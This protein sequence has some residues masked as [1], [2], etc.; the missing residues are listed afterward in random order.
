MGFPIRIFPAI[1]PAHGSPEL[2]AVYH[3]L[4]RHLTPRHPPYA[5]IHFCTCDTEKLIL[6]R[7]YA[8]I[9]LLSCVPELPPAAA[10]KVPL[11]PTRRSQFLHSYL[12]QKQPGT[13]GPGCSL[14][15]SVLVVY[16]KDYSV[17][18]HHQLVQVIVSSFVYTNYSRYFNCICPACQTWTCAGLNDRE[19]R[20]KR[21]VV[22]FVCGLMSCNISQDAL[23]RR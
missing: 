2:F 21:I 5:L 11:A 19:V 12:R 15:H 7:Y 13:S 22:L 18:Q 6:S 1:A 9:R 16:L 4:P 3:V 10:C 23:E 8:C 14:F 20:W 17:G